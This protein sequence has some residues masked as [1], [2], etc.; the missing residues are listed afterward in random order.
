MNQPAPAESPLYVPEPGR[1]AIRDLDGSVSTVAQSDLAA[2]RGEG[3]RPATEA[4]YFGAK[5]GVSGDLAAGAVGAARGATFGVSDPLLLGAAEAFGGNPEE[6][7]R[8]LRLLRE[9]SPNATLAG[10]LGGAGAAAIATGGA[11]GGLRL[12]TG[13]AARVGVGAIEGAG[14]GAASGMGAVLT[15][16]TLEN[17]KSTAEA[18]LS[19][20]VKG[21]AIG[22]LLGG[23]GGG[24]S[25][26]LGRGGARAAEKSLAREEGLAVRAVEGEAKVGGR[27]AI[28]ADAGLAR[29]AGAIERPFAIGKAA[30]PVVL[31]DA[32]LSDL[33]PIQSAKGVRSYRSFAEPTIALD[34]EAGLAAKAGNYEKPFAIG[35]GQEVGLRA[36][37]LPEAAAQA[38]IAVDREILTWP[39]IRP[40]AGLE[41]A[42]SRI[43][44]ALHVESGAGLPR[45]VN[46]AEGIEGGIV[47]RPGIGIEAPV[48]AQAP[49]AA[50]RTLLERIE[51]LRG[52]LAATPPTGPS[53]RDLA[54]GG[55]AL[56]TGHPVAAAGIAVNAARRMYGPQAAAH[57]LDAAIRVD[58]FRRAA[59]KLDEMLISGSKSFASGSK[60]TTRAPKSVTT[61]EVRAIREAVRTPEAV[62]ARVAEHVGDMPDVAPKMAQEIA[63]TAA[64]AAAWLRFAL[65]KEPAPI[66]PRFGKVRDVPLSNEQL[67]DARATI[68]TVADGSIVVDRLL[69]GR[70][71]NTHVAALRYVHPEMF[72]T[73]QKYL[74]QHATELNATLSQ[75][76]LTRLGILFGEPLTEQ[77]LPENIRAFQ[78]SFVQG[79]QAP[80][81]GGDGGNVKM[82]SKPVVGGGTSAT[83]N[84]MLS[85]G[86]SRK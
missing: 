50:P 59:T 20:G 21:G 37:V 14:I 83:Q 72:A 54:L 16:D 24:A 40:D 56:A 71:T 63:S 44:N 32:V 62:T 80:G 69:E 11:T 82:N 78:A 61:E 68:E 58:T 18:Y 46:L 38:P 48:A 23:A 26:L 45:P 17:H 75:Q 74:A 42:P 35:K 30:R 84:D 60:A 6:Y 25:A 41:K 77:D 19:A 79:N 12:G 51:G 67:L 34:A 5:H 1:V 81:E 7:R 13:L 73:I 8:T 15:E 4:E 29:E 55:L 64:R 36:G 65:P 28:D 85:K 9:T 33:R 3:A 52:D 66:A 2:A 47:S 49:A 10:E 70:L 86:G 27:V 39:G 43:K 57:A 76:Q 53:A 22:I 31:D